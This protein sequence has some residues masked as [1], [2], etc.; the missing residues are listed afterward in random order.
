M[1]TILNISLPETMA[2]DVKKHAVAE[3][4]S[5]SE[6]MRHLIR[7]WNTEQLGAQLRRDRKE[8]EQGK[9]KVLRSLKDL[10]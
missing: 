6:F 8:F 7:L 4:Y 2:R 3:G 5:L 1:R 9:G 10:A